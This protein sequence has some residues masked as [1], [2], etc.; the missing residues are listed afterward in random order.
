MAFDTFDDIAEHLPRFIDDVYNARR[1]HSALGYI[2][3]MLFESN[4]SGRRSNQQPDPVRHAG[5]HFMSRGSAYRIDP[6]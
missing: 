3:P 6:R 5:A 2:S 1:L 4:T